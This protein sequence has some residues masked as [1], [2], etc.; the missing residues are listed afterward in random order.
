MPHISLKTPR[1]QIRGPLHMELI[2]EGTWY[3]NVRKEFSEE[4]WDLIRKHTYTEA[5]YVCQICGGVGPEWPVECHERWE[6]NDNTGVQK[7]IGFIALC[8]KCHQVKHIGHSYA[9]LSKTKILRLYS[10]Q[11]RINKWKVADQAVYFEKVALRQEKRN[12]ISWTVDM[13]FAKKLIYD[14][15]GEIP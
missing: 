9:T 14:L 2:P 11:R 8:P 13:T 15:T 12:L 4:H 7:L 6:W 5:G 3:K 10:H 1:P